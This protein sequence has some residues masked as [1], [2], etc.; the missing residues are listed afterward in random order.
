MVFTMHPT[1]IFHGKRA[2]L[3][4]VLFGVYFGG[5]EEREIKSR[6]G[7]YC[8]LRRFSETRIGK[9]VYGVAASIAGG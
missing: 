9:S 6:T 4:G 3:K 5:I 7:K 2:L 8:A 1:A